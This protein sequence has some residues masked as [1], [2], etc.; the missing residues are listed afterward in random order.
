MEMV[1]LVALSHR[2]A[3]RHLL[4]VVLAAF[5]GTVVLQIVAVVAC[6]FDQKAA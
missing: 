6:F 3:F 2:F 5:A 4:A 1:E